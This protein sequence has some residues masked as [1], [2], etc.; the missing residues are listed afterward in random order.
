MATA[1]LLNVRMPSVVV[2][3]R[4]ATVP[5]GVP[6]LLDMIVAVN[7]S[8]LPL[9]AEAAETTNVAVVAMAAAEVMVS[10]VG[11][12]VLLAKFAVPA[13]LQVIE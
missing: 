10:A 8:G 7:A 2:P 12:E 1:L 3:S 13:Y 9:D 6:E 4:K 11:A 5:A